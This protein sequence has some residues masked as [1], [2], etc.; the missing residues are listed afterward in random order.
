[1]VAAQM[2]L[3]AVVLLLALPA[4]ALADPVDDF[5]RKQLAAARVPGLSLAVIKD[6]TVVKVSGYGFADL[7]KRI[8]A[9]PDTVFKIGSVSKQFI[10]T[11]ILLLVQ[12]GRLTLNDPIA[13]YLTD[14]PASWSPITIRH[15]LTHTAGL[16]RESPA[17]APTRIQSDA[18]LIAAAYPLPLRFVPGQKWEYSNLGYVILADIIRGVSGRPWPEF[19]RDRVFA[20]VE[21]SSTWP[22]NT[23]AEIQKRAVGY[24]GNDN[25]RRADDW[26]A[27]RASGAFLSTVLDLAKWDVELGATGILQDDSRRQM[28]TPV[29]LNNGSPAPYGLGWHL[30]T[31]SG[32]RR[33]RH[34]GGL[35]GFISEYARFQ[36][37]R[38]TVIA[39]ANGDDVDLPSLVH[40]IAQLYLSKK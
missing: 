35:P 17:F 3:V 25:S 7:E 19:L 9:Q 30:D 21:M 24:T 22:T 39:L 18:D 20:P 23:K 15:A 36:D 8:P 40:G 27:L 1:M 34:G 10:A 12:D 38:L 16:V 37:D 13:R 11:G 29:R 5:V 28:W 2:R 31:R 32:H 6:G 14:P 4:A 33:I 26:P